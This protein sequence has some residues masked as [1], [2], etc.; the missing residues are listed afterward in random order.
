[1]SLPTL[2]DGVGGIVVQEFLICNLKFWAAA[3][4]L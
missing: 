4:Q 2:I 3:E 1:M